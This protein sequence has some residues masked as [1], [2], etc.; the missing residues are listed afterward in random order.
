MQQSH[1]TSSQAEGSGTRPR[2]HQGQWQE[3]EVR[4][5]NGGPAPHSLWAIVRTWAFPLTFKT[6]GM[7]RILSFFFFLPVASVSRKGVLGYKEQ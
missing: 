5:K 1:R 4:S 2:G 3:Q 6:H 7:V